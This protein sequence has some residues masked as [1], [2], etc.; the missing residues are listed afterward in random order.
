MS[1]SWRALAAALL[2]GSIASTG[3]QELR[4]QQ[5]DG[6][7]LTVI[8][9]QGAGGPF[10]Q[11]IERR[12]PDGSFD[13][14]FGRAGR[15]SFSLRTDNLEPRSIGV[16]AQGRVILSGTA[17]DATGR[18]AAVVSRFMPDGRVD[19]RW[20]THGTS[21]AG[22]AEGHALAVDALTMPDHGMLLL[23]QVETAGARRVVLWRLHIDGSTDIGF[24]RDGVLHLAPLD[25][26]Q[27]ISLRQDGDGSVLIAA[28]RSQAGALMLEVHRWQSSMAVLQLVSQQPAPPGSRGP[29]A[30]ERR[31]GRWLWRDAVTADGMPV[32]LIDN[33]GSHV[34]SPGPASISPFAPPEGYA[35]S[36]SIGAVDPGME[37]VL[38]WALLIAVPL[39]LGLAARR[40]RTAALA[41]TMPP[42]SAQ[43]ALVDAALKELER[44]SQ[45][46]TAER[47]APIAPSVPAHAEPPKRPDAFECPPSNPPDDLKQIKGIGPVLEQRL[48]REGIHYFRQI[49]QWQPEDVRAVAARL[50]AFK[51]RIERDQWVAQ[52]I[53]LAH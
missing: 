42:P 3:A 45:V 27:P 19:S 7:V 35:G 2:C 11:W 41:T 23:G 32:A 24:G 17:R 33:D 14:T 29:F 20:G 21:R 37:P 36:P 48:H 9:D 31:D 4:L 30:L 52:A 25:G 44:R 8:D 1:H 47:P 10:L 46:P 6:K 15:A 18:S 12:N 40:L 34:V 39:L 38:L 28:Q 26:A 43:A 22:S 16:D 49:A 5:P 51:G 50:S 53:E 13:L